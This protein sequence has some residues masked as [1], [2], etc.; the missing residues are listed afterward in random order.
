MSIRKSVIR[1]FGWCVPVLLLAAMLPLTGCNISL[2]GADN[3]D[4]AAE[5]TEKE[6]EAVP[7]EVAALE[8]GHIESVLRFAS[9][10]EA[11]RDVQVYAQAPRIVEQLLVEEGNPVRAGQQ[12]CSVPPW[13]RSTANWK[14]PGGN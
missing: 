4:E 2:G 6:R 13:P 9:N 11:E 7:V 3:D 5:G 12:L 8:R 1:M 14:R 10:L